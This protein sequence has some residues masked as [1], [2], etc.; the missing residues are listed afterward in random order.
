MNVLRRL[1]KRAGNAI[2]IE[3]TRPGTAQKLAALTAN[4]QWLPDAY[5]VALNQQ[6]H[7]PRLVPRDVCEFGVAQGETSALIAN[8]IRSTSKALHRF[9]ATLDYRHTVT[10]PGAIMIVDDY[11][12][13]PTRAWRLDVPSAR[14]GHFAILTRR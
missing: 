14:L 4:F 9:R 11:D 12:F 7:A 8:E 6:P 1:V 2:G 10:A 5:E 3:I 13:F